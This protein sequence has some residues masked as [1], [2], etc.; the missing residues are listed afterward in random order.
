MPSR[1]TGRADLLTAHPPGKGAYVG[2]REPS[3]AIRT[4]RLV[5]TSANPVNDEDTQARMTSDPAPILTAAN[6]DRTR[7]FPARPSEEPVITLRDGPGR[8]RV[9]AD[10]REWADSDGSGGSLTR[11]LLAPKLLMVVDAPLGYPVSLS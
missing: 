1:N 11:F 4:G 2:D 10:G 5:R 6:L 3:A 7:R 8:L 9:A